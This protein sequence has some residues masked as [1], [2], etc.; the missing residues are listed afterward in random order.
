[1]ALK[2]NPD[3]LY[4]RIQSEEMKCKLGRW[5]KSFKAKVNII[6]RNAREV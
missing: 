1:M 6:L 3:K 4:Q 5:K 2:K